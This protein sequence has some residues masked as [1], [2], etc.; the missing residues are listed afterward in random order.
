MLNNWYRSFVLCC[1]LCPLQIANAQ[2]KDRIELYYGIAEGNYLVG[3]LSGAASNIEQ[4]L[5]IDSKY[6]PA[7]TLKSRVLL[8]QGDPAGALTA[9]QE[10]IAIEPANLEHQLLKALILEK[11][12]QE[13]A[14]RELIQTVISKAPTGSDDFRAANQLLGLLQMAGGDWD[15]AADSFNQIYLADPATAATSLKLSSEAYLEKARLALESAES[16]QAIAALDQAIAVFKDK[17][18]IEALKEHTKLRLTRARLLAQIGQFDR[19]IS[20]LQTLAAQ[21]PNNLEAT[22]TLASIYA[23]AERWSSLDQLI[24][25]I[26]TL[27][28]LADIALYFAGRSAYSKGR[29]GSARAKFEEA[30]DLNRE[31]ELTASLHFYRGLCFKALQRHAEAN[32]AIIRALNQNYRPETREESIAASL[33]LI[34]NNQAERAIPILEALTL[35]Q[36]TPTVE[37]WSLLGRAHQIEKT[38]ALAISAYNEA[39]KLDPFDTENRATRGSLLRNIGDIEG[40]ATDYSVARKIDPN[41]AGYAYALALTYLQLG[42]LIEAEV[43]MRFATQALPHNP[44]IQLLHALLAYTVDHHAT[45]QTSLAR[46]FAAIAIDQP[47]ETALYLEYAL[48]AQDDISLANLGL[49]QRLIN[50]EQSELLKKF[51]RYSVGQLDRK[52]I[53]DHAGIA[54]TPQLAKQ[55]ICE[56]AF[57]IAQHERA[58]GNT[59][60]YYELLELISKIGHSDLPEYQFARWQLNN[61]PPQ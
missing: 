44:G 39:I 9:A 3:D 25:T 12:G 41:N 36:I 50:Q 61:K 22:V 21:Q 26:A 60:A 19:S 38:P 40:A 28:E 54:E 49:N 17:T 53:I 48:Q 52:S 31:G 11:T 2:S 16:E 33:A 23:S 56:A 32:T 6:V 37:T 8:D 47:N 42:Q 58:L 55:Q 4:M 57:W 18:G 35:N 43:N 10:T 7:L 5:R 51:V 20:D 46:Y 15:A 29:V 30:L 45:S 27:P 34:E 1:L 13:A 24:P 14:A 59:T